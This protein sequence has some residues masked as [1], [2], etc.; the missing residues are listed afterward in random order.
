MEGIN[1]FWWTIGLVAA[2][3][4]PISLAATFIV[5]LLWL[6]VRS[7][8]CLILFFVLLGGAVFSGLTFGVA[9]LMMSSKWP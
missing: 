9:C 6:G 3:V 7:R 8:S 2:W 1:P 5:G 4:A